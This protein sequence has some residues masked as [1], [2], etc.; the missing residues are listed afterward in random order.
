M[1]NKVP[2]TLDAIIEKYRCF[3]LDASGVLYTDH[4]PVPGS[5]KAYN[6]AKAQG[7]VFITTNNSYCDPSIISD[8]FYNAG[9]EVA[10]EQVISSGSGLCLPELNKLIRG[11]NVWVFG[12]DTSHRY[13]HDAGCK[14]IVPAIEE[15]QTIVMMSTIKEAP[16]MAFQSLKAYCIE[17]PTTPVICCNPERFV[18]GKEGRH[19]VV[20]SVAERLET[21][22]DRPLFWV[23]KPHANYGRLIRWML[24]ERGVTF[25][26]EE[27][28]FLD[29]NIE[30]LTA[31]KQQ[32]GV[33]TCWV[34]ETGLAKGKAQ[35]ALIAEVGVRPDYS[36]PMFGLE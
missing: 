16:E 20:G 6:A 17:H 23:G 21:E 27:T 22:L 4:G 25:Q 32:L 3:F 28:C 34:T 18:Q 11:R 29:D 5:L 33:A 14:S 24:T 26:P 35:D 31:L 1:T 19:P 10:P 9:F 2:I 13:L 12:Y 8:K 36:V 7:P 15:A 30:N